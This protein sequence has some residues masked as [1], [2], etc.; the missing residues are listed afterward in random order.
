MS[1]ISEAMSTLSAVFVFKFKTFLKS[2]GKLEIV[3]D[4]TPIRQLLHGATGKLHSGK[5]KRN[6]VK[7]RTY[8][9]FLEKFIR[10]CNTERKKLLCRNSLLF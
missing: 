6:S 5:S 2:E 4:E 3:E 10:K 9:S 7:V 8:I 1:A